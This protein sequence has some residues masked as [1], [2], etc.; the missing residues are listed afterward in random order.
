MTFTVNGL[1]G[2]PTVSLQPGNT[3]ANVTALQQWLVKNGFL[4][5][6]QM[7]TGVGVY[8]PA[9]TAA[10]ASLQ[11]QLGVN[12]GSSAGYYGPLTIS[13]IQSKLTA[14]A[15]PSRP[16]L[17][18][19][20]LSLT[21]SSLLAGSST[22]V[23]FSI[24]NAGNATA[25]ASTA[26]VYLYS[27]GV[28]VQQL[29]TVSIGA[30]S[31]NGGSSGAKSLSVTVPSNLA[32]G[33][34][35][36]GVTAG[37]GGVSGEVATSNNSFS[38]GLTILPPPRADLIVRSLTIGSPSLAQ[39][40]ST[41]VNFTIQNI[42]TALAGPT[43]TKLYLRNA[44]NVDTLLATLGTSQVAANGGTQS[45]TFTLTGAQ[46]AALAAGNYSIVAV[47]D[48]S[49]AISNEFREDN[50]TQLAGFTIV[51]PPK[52]D[53]VVSGLGWTVSPVVGGTMTLNYTI[54]N[55]G[56]IG[57]GNFLTR[58]YL[59]RDAAVDSSDTILAT[60]GTQSL[61]A[62][63]STSGSV[64]VTVPGSYAAGNYSIIA[65]TD[66]TGIV[67]ENRED[68]NSRLTQ[69]TILPPPK[70]D[71][72]VTSLGVNSSPAVGGSTTLN[73]TIA[74][75][76][77]LGAG[78][79]QTR[80]YLSR[81]GTVDSGDAMLAT[82]STSSLGAG[83]QTTGSVQVTVP[84][85]YAA[86]TYSIIAVTDYAGAVGEIKEDNNSRTAGI[87]IQSTSDSFRAT[88][89]SSLK[90]DVASVVDNFITPF[91][92]KSVGGQTLASFINQMSW[93]DLRNY[94]VNDSEFK[95]LG[96]VQLT[97]GGVDFAIG[98]VA[99]LVTSYTDSKYGKTS[100]ASFTARAAGMV[101]SNVVGGM[102]LNLGTTIVGGAFDVVALVKDFILDP[103]QQFYVEQHANLTDQEKQLQANT[104][105]WAQILKDK[106]LPNG[107]PL[108][109]STEA[110]LKKAVYQDVPQLYQQI[111]VQKGAGFTT[112]GLLYNMG[113]TINGIY[114]SIKSVV[115][116]V[117][118][119]ITNTVSGAA[120][121]GQLFVNSLA[122]AALS[123]ASSGLLGSMAQT[124]PG[125]LLNKNMPGLAQN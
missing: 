59:S 96:A 60:F 2:Y 98:V 7:N 50:N 44:N 38:T 66:Y 46:T 87:T 33:N 106:K 24:G 39:G 5:Q 49:N 116:S 89:L 37:V 124:T 78:F 62:F 43:T 121:S 13:A 122:P 114:S 26:G 31:A 52:P 84:S 4:T 79:F 54:T 118:N 19:N 1:T 30:I 103:I 90:P 99:K 86:G 32:A 109:A 102:L 51:P 105:V 117:W 107:T 25:A 113:E 3:G 91:L 72:T 81:D 104:L 68:N 27:N 85:S 110:A 29:G 119:F 21:N 11:T 35:T 97:A 17:V 63:A 115:G 34:Y 64:Q 16:D 28:L 40:S 108:N 58:I 45:G 111:L 94:V 88:V 42:G 100:A 71:L 23:N 112:S 57:A 120:S 41:T 93:T 82:V 101:A 20:S 77:N 12:A 92:N 61:A 6:A 125:T 95:R 56:S 55:Q 65:V 75:Q 74:N 22:T 73:Y 123:P 47:A 36:I 18:I 70:A 67:G 80:F 83:L 14:L 8:G 48:A 76:G 53:L 69:V 10:V 9:T 15:T